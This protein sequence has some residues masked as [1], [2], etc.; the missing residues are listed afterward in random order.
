MS[1][2]ER[3]R[4]IQVVAS[5]RLHFGLLSFGHAGRRQFG[6]VG[7][8]LQ[9][10][11]LE[12]FFSA[13]SSFDVTGE[14]SNRVLAF[15]QH[16]AQ[17]H[18]RPELPSCR[19]EVASVPREHVGLGVGTQ[20]GLSVASGLNRL[21]Q[22]PEPSLTELVQSVGRGAR[23][24][25]GSYGFSSGGLIVD[26]GKMATEQ[27]SPLE[28]QLPIP[29]AWRWVLICPSQGSGLS[30]EREGQAFDQLQPV[31]E[32]VSD[33]LK[34][35]IQEEMLPAVREHQFERFSQAVFRFGELAGS[36]FAAVQGG[37]YHGE[38]LIQRVGWLRSLG[39]EG[40]GQSSWGPTLFALFENE[41]AAEEFVTYAQ[42]DPMGERLEYQI[43]S[44]DNCGAS[45]SE[46]LSVEG[47]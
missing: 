2:S 27:I 24:A 10:P 31:P 22:C 40:V 20:L 28:S 5:S 18:G 17:W 11:S 6:G 3:L 30:G 8:M 1:A 39:I 34:N 36:C 23:S 25:V 47:E 26:A 4:R 38:E 13:S 44:T 41:S 35:E 15:V 7:V 45:I 14:L 19:I 43:A 29:A 9:Q 33:R 37:A 42:Q 46:S 12:L 32:E 21:L 16:W